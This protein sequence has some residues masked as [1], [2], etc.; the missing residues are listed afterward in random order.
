MKEECKVFGVKLIM[1]SKV[2]Q[3]GTNI[4]FF[5]VLEYSAECSAESGAKQYS[6]KNLL[7]FRGKYLCWSLFLI[8]NIERFFKLPRTAAS[9]NDH[10]TTDCDETE[11]YVDK[12]F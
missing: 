10:E 8:Q 5:Y 11:K 4:L 2:T 12:G 3:E 9:E 7:I 1:W 6:I